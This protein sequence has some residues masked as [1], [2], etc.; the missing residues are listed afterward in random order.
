MMYH[1]ESLFPLDFMNLLTTSGSLLSLPSIFPNFFSNKSNP[2]FSDSFSPLFLLS[3]SSLLIEKQNKSKDKIWEKILDMAGR[4]YKGPS[5][6][7]TS[8]TEE[9][10]SSSLEKMLSIDWIMYLHFLRFFPGLLSIFFLFYLSFFK[11]T[12]KIFN[13]ILSKKKKMTH[14]LFLSLSRFRPNRTDP[15]I[16]KTANQRS[17][18]ARQSITHPSELG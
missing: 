4:A 10:F 7:S 18:G 12:L 9:H 16:R 11:K 3:P 6:P 13:S 17:K 15:K 1:L 14:S 2:L 8:F 5:F